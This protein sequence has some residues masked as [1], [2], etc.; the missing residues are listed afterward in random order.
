MSALN[1]EALGTA[2]ETWPKPWEEYNL[3]EALKK[4]IAAYLAHCYKCDPTRLNTDIETAMSA[5]LSAASPKGQVEAVAWQYRVMFDEEGTREEWWEWQLTSQSHFNA[6]NVQIADGR[7][8]V[9]TRSLYASP[10]PSG[11]RQTAF[12]DDDEPKTFEEL[13]DAAISDLRHYAKDETAHRRL[14]SA[15][16]YEERLALLRSLAAPSQVEG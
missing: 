3:G 9:Q 7:K 10:A 4:A 2:I 5:A 16:A 15:E 14:V 1:P 6:L 13:A 8:R 11:G 12:P